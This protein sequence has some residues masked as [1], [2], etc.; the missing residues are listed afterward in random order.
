MLV[1]TKEYDGGK[2]KHALTAIFGLVISIQFS[3]T[4]AAAIVNTTRSNI[5]SIALGKGNWC[6]AVDGQIPDFDSD[7]DGTLDRVV[8]GSTVLVS[9]RAIGDDEDCDGKSDERKSGSVVQGNDIGSVDVTYEIVKAS[10]KGSEIP[11]LVAEISSISLLTQVSRES[12]NSKVVRVVKEI[13]HRVEITERKKLY[14]GNLPF[15]STDES[16]TVLHLPSVIQDEVIHYRMTNKVIVIIRAP[17][18]R[19]IVA[20]IRKP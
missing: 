9:V 3:A 11:N 13:K 19:T 4:P 6:Y 18:N 7:D 17:L 16:R 14:V 15:S 5:K 8:P 1:A 12:A 10:E 2:M 20:G